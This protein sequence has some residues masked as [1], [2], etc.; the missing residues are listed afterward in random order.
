MMLPVSAAFQAAVKGTHVA[1]SRVE[2]WYGGARIATTEG[3]NRLPGLVE[4]TVTVDAG[5]SVRR[6]YAASFATPSAFPGLTDTA[7]PFAPYG[8][9]HR[10][11]RGVVYPNGA[12]EWV[13]LG[14]FRLDNPGVPLEV[15]VLKVAGS[16]LSRQ[17]QDNRLQTPAGTITTNTVPVEI[18]RYLRG[19]M[20]GP[21]PVRDLTGNVSLAPAVT[22]DRDRWAGI[23][24][25]ALSIGAEIVFGVDGTALIQNVPQ[26][27]NSIVW[28]VNYNEIMITGSRELDRSQTYNCVVA[29][30]ER[31]DNVAPARAVAY[32]LNA[33]SPTYV[34]SPIGSGPFGLVPAFYSSP[35]LS[36]NTACQKAA[37][38]ILGR[39]RGMT[40]RVSFDCVPNPAVDVGDVLR[41]NLPN[42]SS[43]VHIVDSLQIPLGV[44]G[45]MRVTTRTSSE[46]GLS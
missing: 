40:R 30:G 17:V 20:G 28:T 10:V 36:T 23:S 15:G 5:Q 14:V 45:T 21:W 16:D 7:G 25:L 2:A 18:A 27:T 32:D 6:S 43:E 12:R 8:T 46:P 1:E 42:G 35:A 4:G 41:V 26:V 11:W 9:Q 3:D 37:D 44:E 29:T 31:T 24:D 13:Q 22:W 34:G 19:A 33:S 38:T 39:V